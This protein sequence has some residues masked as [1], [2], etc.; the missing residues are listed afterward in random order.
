MKTFKQ[1]DFYGQVIT[2]IVL[3]VLSLVNMDETFVY[4]YFIIGAWQVLSM[5]IHLFHKQFIPKKS[6]RLNYTIATGIMV[7]LMFTLVFFYVLLFIAPILALY[8][9]YICGDELFYKMKRRPL[10][11]LK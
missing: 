2:I 7:A 4:S 10:Y 11:Q 5:V 1:I 8:Y 6:M 9:L 3:T